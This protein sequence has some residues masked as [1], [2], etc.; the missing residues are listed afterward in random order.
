MHVFNSPTANGQIWRGYM[1]LLVWEARFELA[2]LAASA[3]EADKSTYSIIP[4]S[5]VKA[6]RFDL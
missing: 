1:R 4:T 3:S 5:N 6:L 2:R